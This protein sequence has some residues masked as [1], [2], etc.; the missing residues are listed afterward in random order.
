MKNDILVI[1]GKKKEPTKIVV[2]KLILIS[3]IIKDTLLSIK[4][5]SI[6]V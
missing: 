5:I 6:S 1:N 2:K 4:N 3:F